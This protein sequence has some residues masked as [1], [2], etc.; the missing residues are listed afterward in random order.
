MEAL[1]RVSEKVLTR[2]RGID[3]KIRGLNRVQ[4][5]ELLNRLV[6]NAL[7]FL[8]RSIFDL[9]DYPKYSIINFYT[10]VELFVKARLMAEHWSLVVA[11]RQEPDWA[12]FITGDFQ[13]VS[14]EEAATRLEKAARSGLFE[15]EIKAFNHVRTHR[16]KVVHFFHEAHSVNENEE[17]RRSIAK[18]QL[19][20][21]YLLHCVLTVRWK[22]VFA[23]WT[24]QIAELD[25]KVRKH[26]TYLQIVFDHSK[27]DLTDLKAKGLLIEVCPS[28]AFESQS[29]EP[30]L[31]ELYS[32]ECRV[33]GLSQQCVSIACPNCDTRVVFRNEGFAS[34][35]SC[36]KSLEPDA[37]AEA[38]ID[39]AEAHYAAKDG[40]DSLQPGNCSDCDGFHTVVQLGETCF[41]TSCF[42][43][44]DK[45]EWC[46]WCNEANTGDME[47][48]YFS[49]CNF[50]EGQADWTRDD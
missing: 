23:P 31:N 24:Q 45:L 49:G 3:S 2:I 39:P 41:C 29:H 46:E 12:K 18:Q 5:K 40:D 8:S 13:S 38:I 10:A 4:A 48:S 6:R 36:G 7:D 30:E 37:L 27:L 35:E 32:A 33:C 22:D 15:H 34:C 9:E 47:H 50:C 43:Q 25:S 17:L 42:G 19:T 21:W 14:L 1:L 44:F 16:N 11:K 20:A 28:C 26:H